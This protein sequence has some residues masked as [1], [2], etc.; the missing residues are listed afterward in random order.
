MKSF[1]ILFITVFIFFSCKTTS[2]DN[3]RSKG[4]TDRVLT[5][6]HCS[7]VDGG[8]ENL[9]AVAKAV[10]DKGEEATIVFGG[11]NHATEDLGATF[12]WTY[13]RN[14]KLY[15][16]GFNDMTVAVIKGTQKKVFNYS[17]PFED[18]ELSMGWEDKNKSK[19]SSLK[20]TWTSQE[21]DTNGRISSFT[22]AN[23]KANVFAASGNSVSNASGEFSFQLFVNNN[24]RI[25]RHEGFKRRA[26]LW[27]MI[28]EFGQSDQCINPPDQ[29]VK[30]FCMLAGLDGVPLVEDDLPGLALGEYPFVL[31]QSKKSF[32]NIID[33][34]QQ[35]IY[36]I[37]S[38][39]GGLERSLIDIIAAKNYCF[40]IVDFEKLLTMHM[41]YD[42]VAVF[43][44]SPGTNG[45]PQEGFVGYISSLLN[46]KQPG[47]T[48]A[49]LMNDFVRRNATSGFF[50]SE[51]GE[52]ESIN[53]RAYE[54]LKNVRDIENVKELGFSQNSGIEYNWNEMPVGPG[55]FDRRIVELKDAQ[56]SCQWY[57]MLETQRLL[58]D[59]KP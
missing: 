5:G 2:Q 19:S 53:L 11:G 56:T 43:P 34:G 45:C 28:T 24:E 32:L 52:G 15:G 6:G 22:F 8:Y 30:D 29:D 39:V 14:G 4:I 7:R 38:I 12:P 33:H 23:Q 49:R 44:A 21:K 18:K 27:D 47:A 59:P 26:A 1:A 51:K 3:S 57:G 10:N 13:F 55:I 31:D 40:D 20:I 42:Y 50:I 9:V 37:K 41:Q 54:K 35:E 46:A 58:G 25:A 48:A 36:T 16:I 17:A